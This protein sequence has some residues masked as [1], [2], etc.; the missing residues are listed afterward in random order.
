MKNVKAKDGGRKK[1]AFVDTL[2][3]LSVPLQF[4]TFKTMSHDLLVQVAYS[5]PKLTKSSS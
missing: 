2:C 1:S 3:E 5:F 4:G